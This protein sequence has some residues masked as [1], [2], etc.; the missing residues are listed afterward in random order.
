MNGIMICWRPECQT[1]AGC[2]C[3]RVRA[4]KVDIDAIALDAAKKIDDLHVQAHAARAQRTARVQ[5]VVREAIELALK[6]RE[7]AS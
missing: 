7:I 1:A 6:G 5:I 3:D 4:A 2:Q